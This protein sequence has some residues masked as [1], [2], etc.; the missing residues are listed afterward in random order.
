[1]GLHHVPGVRLQE[2]ARELAL[3]ADF[4]GM[5]G[6]QLGLFGEIGGEI[7]HVFQVGGV[8]GLAEL[9][10]PT[11]NHGQAHHGER[12]AQRQQHRQQ[13]S[14]QVT[15]LDRVSLGFHR[16]RHLPMVA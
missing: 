4:Q 12:Q 6:H 15:V 8:V 16:C 13:R 5:G 9:I 1:M 7:A 14:E 11:L 2:G 10:V 3:Q